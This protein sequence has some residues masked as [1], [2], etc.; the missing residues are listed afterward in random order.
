MC[1]ELFIISCTDYYF[2]CQCLSSLMLFSPK[3]KLIFDF[4]CKHFYILCFGLLRSHSL[5]KAG[6]YTCVSSPDCPHVIFFFFK[7]GGKTSLL[8]HL[9]KG[10]PLS[11]LCKSSKGV[12]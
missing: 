6:A 5:A 12:V 10:S 8:C 2:N 7:R 4:Q 3:S 1:C 11:I 9:I